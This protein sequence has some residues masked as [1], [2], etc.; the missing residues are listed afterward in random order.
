[1]HVAAAEGLQPVRRLG[2]EQP[3]A[4]RADALVASHGRQHPAERGRPR[5]GI[6]VEQPDPVEAVLEKFCQDCV[7]AGTEAEVARVAAQLQL[8]IRRTQPVD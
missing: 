6:V 5:G 2:V 1:M 7:L 4:D 3:R 8:R